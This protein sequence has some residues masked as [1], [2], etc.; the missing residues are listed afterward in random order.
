MT[1]HQHWILAVACIAGLATV[2]LHFSTSQTNPALPG[3][4]AEPDIYIEHPVWSQFDNKGELSRRL[5]ADRLEQWPDEPDA[6]LKEPRLTLLDS[7]QQPW[8]ANARKGRIGQIGETRATLVLEHQ[9]EL[10]REPPP[11][12][13]VLRT[14]QLRV[15]DRGNLVETNQPVVLKSGSWQVSAEGFRAELGNQQLE[16]IGNVR[17]IH[18]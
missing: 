11:G 1:S 8:N 3:L 2:W 5:R 9:V 16:L 10:S 7:R 14:E 15:A 18:E 17:G 13:L 4:S 6:R 12:G